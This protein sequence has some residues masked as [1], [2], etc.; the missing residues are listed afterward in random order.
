MPH[1]SRLLGSQSHCRGRAWAPRQRRAGH[2]GHGPGQPIP[3]QD[4]PAGG[5]PPCAG[6]GLTHEIPEPQLVPTACASLG[7]QAA[8]TSQQMVT[9]HCHGLSCFPPASCEK[10]AHGAGAAFGSRPCGRL[11][12]AA[13]SERP[14]VSTA[15]GESRP[16]A[17][18]VCR[19]PTTAH[20][21]S[22][23]KPPR[24]SNRSQSPCLLPAVNVTGP[25]PAD[26]ELLKRKI[27]PRRAGLRRVASQPRGLVL[28]G[29][30]DLPS[31]LQDVSCEDVSEPARTLQGKKLSSVLRPSGGRPLSDNQQEKGTSVPRL[32]GSHVCPQPRELGRGTQTSP[33]PEGSPVRP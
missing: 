3:T 30:R 4:L 24:N 20:P 12:H 16:G 6:T 27:D 25:R 7:P 8:H 2:A 11:A 15:R 17:L 13:R 10:R 1:A 18:Q 26:S 29:E 21:L 31:D 19:P 9:S 23:P 33:H 5:R 22:T 32:R 14:T 28:P